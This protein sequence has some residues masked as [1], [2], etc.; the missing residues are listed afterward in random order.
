MGK[1]AND[2]LREG[3]RTALVV[4]ALRDARAAEALARVLGRRSA[5][6]DEVR[7]AIAR[8][9]RCGARDRIE[10]RIGEL[11]RQ[12]RAALE[13][14]SLAPAGRALLEPTIEAL[15]ERRS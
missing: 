12:S 4:E 6:D 9:E 10:A 5:S 1:P 7:E 2:D 3:K 11:T 15:T 13:R 14:A 8:I